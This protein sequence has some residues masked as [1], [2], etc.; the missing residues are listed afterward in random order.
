[1]GIWFYVL[2][3]LLIVMINMY[4][5]QKTEKKLWKSE[6]TITQISVIISAIIYVFFAVF[7]NVTIND[8]LDAY[9]YYVFF[10]KADMPLNEFISESIFELGYTCFTWLCRNIFKWYGIQLLIEYSFIYFAYT[11]LFCYLKDCKYKFFA[12]CILGINLFSA[13][14]ILRMY[15]SIA[16]GIFMLLY[17]EKKKYGRAFLFLVVSILFHNSA[18][19]LS[20]VYLFEFILN[21]KEKFSK[22]KLIGLTM[23]SLVM[24]LIGINI[25]KVFFERSEKYW[26]YANSGSVALGT[27]LCTAIVIIFSL[28]KQEELEN[29]FP[30]SRTMLIAIFVLILVIPLQL[31]ISIMYRMLL[32]FTPLLCIM[33]IMLMHVYQGSRI[34]WILLAY[35]AFYFADQMISFFC[36]EIQY[37]GIPYCFGLNL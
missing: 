34:Y 30:I 16:L 23:G 21:R 24:V 13:Y 6:I 37:V 10:E 29:T 28:Y 2:E 5:L 4:G 9:H 17:L 1:M 26:V 15:I 32:F 11:K 7:R 31:E 33:L 25:L 3:L 18:L 14:Y 35:S 12:L 20:V 22:L 8:T 27:C 36:N 19:I